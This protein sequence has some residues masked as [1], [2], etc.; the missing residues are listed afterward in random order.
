MN[1][2]NARF[3]SLMKEAVFG[4]TAY[5]GFQSIHMEPGR[6]TSRIEVQGHHLQQDGFVHAGV[7]ATLADHTAGYAAYTL[8][9]EDHRILTVEFK[10]NFLAPA[11]GEFVE[12]RANVIKPG[13]R[14]LVVESEVFGIRNG[15][16][17]MAAKALLTMAAV[18]HARVMSR[19]SQGVEGSR[20][21]ENGSV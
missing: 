2:S 19:T 3:D 8:I 6:F 12:C 7:L 4:F 16:E 1:S 21:Q 10:I 15:S 9:P 13:R 18:P 14:I 20:G 5:C 17:T 11:R